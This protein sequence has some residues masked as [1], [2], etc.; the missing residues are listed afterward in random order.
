[1]S[2]WVRN[3]A[4]SATGQCV[5]LS[6]T[7]GGAVAVRDSRDP[8]GPALVYTKTEIATFVASAK[9]GEFDWLIA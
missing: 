5:E 1:M 9:T 3:A 8:H 7:A 6:V 4:S 2:K